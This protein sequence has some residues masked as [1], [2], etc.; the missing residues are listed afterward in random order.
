MVW[1]SK[2]GADFF[3]AQTQDACSLN[4]SHVRWL[5]SET[6]TRFNYHLDW[7]FSA[8]YQQWIRRSTRNTVMDVMKVDKVDYLLEYPFLPKMPLE[9]KLKVDRQMHNVQKKLQTIQK[10]KG[11]NFKFSNYF[12]LNKRFTT[13]LRTIFGIRRKHD[14]KPVGHYRHDP[15][16]C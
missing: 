2:T 15:K 6:P 11:Q 4:D 10:D 7:Y 5:Q 1:L 14:S 16:I 9:E 3:L 8:C 13:F 12:G